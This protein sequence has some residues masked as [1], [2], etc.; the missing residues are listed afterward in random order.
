MAIIRLTL[1]ILGCLTILIP[2]EATQAGSF[3]I[4]AGIGYDYFS[5]NYHLDSLT[6]DTLEATLAL[7]STYFDNLKGLLKRAIPT[8][9]VK[10][11]RLVP[12]FQSR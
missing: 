11:M 1:T 6:T 2:F 12:S 3:D 4:S 7:S 10:R 9:C 8:F 5:Q